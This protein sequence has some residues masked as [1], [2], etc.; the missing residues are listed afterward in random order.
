MS[1][2]AQ[3]QVSKVDESSTLI[4]GIL[5]FSNE[6]GEQA[7]FINE[8]AKKGADKSKDGL[9]TIGN[10]SE[11]MT[12]IL[13]Y[14]KE[15]DISITS[16][17]QRSDEISRVLSIMKEIAAQTNLL[18]L[19]AAIEAAQAGDAGRGFAVVA[20]EVRKL[21]EGSKNSAKEIEILIDDIQ[22]DTKSTARLIAEMSE[23]IRG[24]EV[25]S[26]EAATAF[27]EMATS[28][29]QTLQLSEKIVKATKQ[30]TVDIGNIVGITESVVVIAEETAT[31]TEQV[32]SSS[33]ELS[34]GMTTFSDK[35]E[36]VMDTVNE[37]KN[38]V[39]KFKL[40][41]KSYIDENGV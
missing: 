11:G 2:G 29:A 26:K 3:S 38:Q 18:A 7:E 10:L 22:N 30:Q 34:A 25:N 37:L 14:S 36:Q 5:Q 24:G 6:M 1:K 33:S 23:R 15:T 32:A 40:K 13:E 16:L 20:E 9:Q 21:A 12:E 28:Y 27:E 31:G 17:T 41:D 4:E 19:N 35:S 8:T 39:G